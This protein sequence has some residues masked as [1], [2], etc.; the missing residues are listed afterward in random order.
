MI[1][2]RKGVYK[3]EPDSVQEV[4]LFEFSAQCRKAIF[5][6][7]RHMCV[8]C[9]RGEADGVTLAAEHIKPKDKG[10]KNT[11]DNGKTLCYEH[12]L[13]KRNYSQTEAGKRYFIVFRAF[14]PAALARLE[15]YQVPSAPETT[16]TVLSGRNARSCIVSKRGF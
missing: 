5:E 9:G 14:L 15:P 1:K 3:Y 13:R 12:N 8:V 4:V 11:I 6:R 2:V 7:D 10:G 16:Q